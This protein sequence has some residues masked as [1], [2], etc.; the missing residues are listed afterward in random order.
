MPRWAWAL[1]GSAA[2]WFAGCAVGVAVANWYERAMYPPEPDPVHFDVG[3]VFLAAWV[4][5][6]LA[7]TGG[8]IWLAYRRRA[9]HAEPSAAADAAP[10]AG[11]RC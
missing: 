5:A 4:L 6:W 8:S 3:G 9:R 11:P 2:N 1:L 7:G 10:K